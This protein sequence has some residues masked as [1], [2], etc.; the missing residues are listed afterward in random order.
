MSGSLPAVAHLSSNPDASTLHC[1]LD[2][3][4]RLAIETK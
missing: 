1:H 4:A 3:V 2:R